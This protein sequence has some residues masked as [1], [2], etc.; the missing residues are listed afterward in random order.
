MSAEK[1]PKL[2]IVAMCVGIVTSSCFP[3]SG[4]A[5]QSK[6]GSKSSRSKTSDRVNGDA[7]AE[8]RAQLDTL[9]KTLANG[10]A[11]QLASFWTEDGTYTDE[12]GAI[13]KGR[14]ALEERF[15]TIIS[16]TGNP[17]VEF[18]PDSTRSL[19]DNIVISEGIVKR[20]DGAKRTPETRYSL[21]LQ[22]QKDGTWLIS[23]A[24]ETPF[25]ASA[26]EDPLT[27]LAWMIGEW[28]AD[29]S[30]GASVRMKA[31]W[32][33]NKHFITCNYSTQRS[34]DSPTV[35]SKQVI[36]WDPRTE[37]PIS[38]HFDASGGFGYGNWSMRDGKWYIQSTGVDRDGS[39]TTATNV[40]SGT[41]G[42]S[43]NWQSVNRTVDGV[44]YTD[45]SPLK[46]EKVVK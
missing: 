29:N 15:A 45:T 1:L 41:T 8:V 44:S 16:D 20:K 6:S 19:A 39:T 42:N 37:N 7:T 32:A 34:A 33:A 21:V 23:S 43:F 22:K 5:K 27:G 18:S 10:T 14:S 36:G 2:L 46:V 17:T 4:E 31:D 28:S 3:L 30:K 9:E 11:K 24:T 40:I 25:L 35:E 38:W 26:E 13:V 12:A